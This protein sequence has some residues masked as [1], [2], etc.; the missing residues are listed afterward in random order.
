M[1]AAFTNEL[2]C[3]YNMT[4]PTDL[5]VCFITTSGSPVWNILY[6][7]ILLVAVGGWSSYRSVNEGMM[8]GGFLTSLVGLALIALNLIS[9]KIFMLAFLILVVG[10]LIT[11]I[12]RSKGD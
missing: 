7:C 6:V 11:V 2:G 4:Q 12:K 3:F 5:L 8:I 10:L 1:S 9:V